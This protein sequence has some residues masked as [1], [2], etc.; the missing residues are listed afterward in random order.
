M[1]A[2]NDVSIRIGREI[3]RVAAL[4]LA[5]MLV[6]CGGGKSEDSGGNG[7][8]GNNGGNTAPPT[9]AIVT[10]ASGSTVSGSV[11]V[12]ATAAANGGVAGV[13]FQLDGANIGAED[14]ADPFSATLDTTI[15]SDGT[16]TLTAIARDGAG[17]LITSAPVTVM[18]ANTP[19]PPDPPP[20][21]VA[22]RAEETDTAV[23]LSPGWTQAVP[24]WYARSGG[25]AVQSAVPSATATYTFTGTSVTWIGQRSNISGIALV[26]V[27][28]GAGVLV[29]LFAH[30]FETNSPVYTV[31]GLS[32][33]THTLTIQVTGTH[34][35]LSQGNAV[36]VD[37]FAI[38][39]S[40]VSHLQETDPDVAFTGVWAQ[41]DNND[42]WS[43]GGVRTVPLDPVGGARVTET[44]GSKVTLTFRGT[45]VSWIGFRGRDGGRASVT[46][47]GGAPTVVDTYSSSFQMQATVFTATGL[48]DVP[49]TLTIE[50]LGTH[51]SLSTASKIIVDAFDVT[52]PGRRYEEEDPAVVYSPGNWIFRNVNRTW[53]EGSVSESPVAGAF[54]EFTFTGTS[55]SWIGCRKLSTGEADIYLDGILVQ[56]LSTWLAPAPPGTLAV[57]TEAYQTTIY[58]IDNLLLASHT[59]KIV[60]TSDTGSYT[61]IDAFD[62]RP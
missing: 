51:N 50:A 25:S 39:A 49:H 35:R 4:L 7:S 62:V 47:D 52:T 58:R 15:A 56:H 31:N 43:G 53:S 37:A 14:T 6:S 41:A 27:D 10:P 18:M 9:V 16:H 29:D 24:D 3:S 55:V 32:P 48:D 60:H 19:L 30:N 40:V 13:Q 17:N 36:V 42:G 46:V 23:T 20:P 59:L 26:S 1:S 33:G 54:V 21:P 11:N 12:T 2:H 61:V 45:A 38:P 5:G 8:T 57:G 34:N 44:S 28:G 22:G